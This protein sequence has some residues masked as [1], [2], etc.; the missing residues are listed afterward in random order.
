MRI[1]LTLWGSMAPEHEIASCLITHDRS[2]IVT[3]STTGQLCIWSLDITNDELES[4][5]YVMLGQHPITCLSECWQDH[6]HELPGRARDAAILAVCDDGS[7]FII[8]PRDGRV[9]NSKFK[10]VQGKPRS[11]TVIGHGHYAAVVGNFEDVVIV[12]LSSLQMAQRLSSHAQGDWHTCCCSLKVAAAQ[13]SHADAIAAVSSSNILSIYGCNWRAFH[14][15]AT[16][17][18][19]SV[20]VRMQGSVALS[21]NKHNNAAL[22]LVGPAEWQV[23]SLPDLTVIASATTPKRE[24]RRWLGAAFADPTTVYSWSSGGTLYQYAI[25]HEQ[26]PSKNNGYISLPDRTTSDLRVA[27]V[28]D[29]LQELDVC[30]EAV[31]A[32]SEANGTPLFFATAAPR[33]ATEPWLFATG[34]DGAALEVWETGLDHVRELRS[35]DG[36]SLE[37]TQGRRVTGSFGKAWNHTPAMVDGLQQGDRV[38]AFATVAVTPHAVDPWLCF[39][40]AKGDLIITSLLAL[41]FNTF[42]SDA[43]RNRRDAL[44]VASASRHKAH[45]GAITTMLAPRPGRQALLVTAGADCRVCVWDVEKSV[46]LHSL[47]NQA[48]FAIRLSLTHEALLP[49]W[50][51]CICAVNT[52]NSVCLYDIDKGLCALR[53]AGHAHPIARVKWLPED[54]FMVVECDNG[55]IYIW[56]LSSSHIE[57]T[58]SGQIAQ[59]ILSLAKKSIRPKP[60][61]YPLAPIIVKLGPGDAD[62]ILT[63]ILDVARLSDTISRHLEV[64]RR[65]KSRTVGTTQLNA[66]LDCITSMLLQWDNVDILQATLDRLD[67]FGQ[68]RGWSFGVVG[69]GDRL[70]S[71]VPGAKPAQAWQLS[72]TMST[73]RLIAICAVTHARSRAVTSGEAEALWLQVTSCYAVHTDLHHDAPPRDVRLLAHFWSH[74]CIDLQEAAHMLMLD[75]LR[76]VDDMSVKVLLSQLRSDLPDQYRA[77]TDDEVESLLLLSVLANMRRDVVPDEVIQPLSGML[78]QLLQ[79]VNASVSQ[80]CTAASALSIAFKALRTLD[81]FNSHRLM[82]Y[83][84]ST[85]GH[86][87][88]RLALA[89]N[90][91]LSAIAI[92]SPVAFASGI[93]ALVEH[94]QG[95][96]EGTLKVLRRMVKDRPITLVAQMSRIVSIILKTLDPNAPTVRDHC[97]SAAQAVLMDMKSIYPMFDAKSGST[98]H[99][100]SRIAVGQTDGSVVVFDAKTSSRWLEFVAHEH[101]VTALSFDSRCKRLATFAAADNCLRLFQLTSPLFGVLGGTS[102]MVK[103]HRIDDPGLARIPMRKL[104]VSVRMDWE[105]D[106]T[107]CLLVGQKHEIRVAMH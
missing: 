36:Q 94:Q 96:P 48:G 59:D 37:E 31:S 64:T 60:E 47:F 81:G 106:K 78:H 90:E 22:L 77:T 9:V 65:P 102:K 104:L 4:K 44:K 45:D 35:R 87:S 11:L 46:L 51:N 58:A 103:E 5:L 18:S 67:L 99:A 95:Y 17:P 92:E 72:S 19:D 69:Q 8:D 6:H 105:D 66:L 57:S 28:S 70:T 89:C 76:E 84:V 41:C 50:R 32:V 100:T 55:A 42:D 73:A 68:A 74:R 86:K 49:K 1:P 20:R 80:R 12:D 26:C 27:P 7:M 91:A 39:G 13:N 61:A 25:D 15:G 52:D 101:A 10:A 23:Y 38:S 53:V 63:L 85:T 98:Q 88:P 97:K 21:W 24:D 29:T 30:Q 43:A 62:V 75:G 3:G 34:F 83:L 2:F 16:P 33:A 14:K 40:T 56:Q 107:V 54:D 93:A 71:M 79:D 82:G